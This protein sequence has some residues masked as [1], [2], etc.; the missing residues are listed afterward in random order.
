MSLKLQVQIA[1]IGL[2]IVGSMRCDLV[3]ALDPVGTQTH[4]FNE[5]FS[6]KWC[7]GCLLHQSDKFL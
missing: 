7:N 2:T 5:V 1:L 3:P 4:L 6:V